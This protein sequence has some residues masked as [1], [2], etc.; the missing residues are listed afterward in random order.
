MK[1]LTLISLLLSSHLFGQIYTGPIEKPTSGYGSDGTHTIGVEAFSNP[2]FPSMDIEIY[3]PSDI[4]TPVPTL[5]YSHAYGGNLSFTVQ[6]LLN[7]A[8]R[9]GYA[10]V[11]VP[12]QTSGVTVVERYENLL[13]GFRKAARDFPEIIDTTRVGFMGHSFGGGAS[14]ATAYR[15]FTENDWGVNGRWI[16]SSAPWYLYNISQTELTT[17]PS[18]V[19]LVVEVYNDDLVN[20][21]RMAADAFMNINIPNSEKDFLKVYADSSSGYVYTAKHDL[22]MAYTDFNAMDYYAYFR[23]LDALCDYTFNGNLAGKEVALGNGSA[24]QVQ[25][26]VGLTN[27]EQTDYPTVAVPESDYGFACSSLANPRNDYCGLLTLPE[28]VNEITTY[29]FPNPVETFL[30]INLSPNKNLSVDIYNLQGELVLSESGSTRIDVS[31][32][33]AGIYLCLLKTDSQYTL[34]KFIKH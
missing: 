24:S 26:P 4:L 34:E 1:S 2:Y 20:D 7:W 17:F 30:N 31:Q 28:S 22:P 16:H 3:H 18:D 29:L 33:R 25:M 21:H 12:Y 27:L 11:F 32:L 13:E 23:L 19:K 8:A 10:I 15:C 5:F 9:K 14:F 6:G